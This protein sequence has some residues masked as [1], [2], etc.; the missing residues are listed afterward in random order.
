MPGMTPA[1]AGEMAEAAAVSLESQSHTQGVEL[2]V[3]AVSPTAYQLTWST[4][5]L[6]SIDA[7]N[8]PDDATEAGAVAVAA[9]MTKRHLGYEIIRRSRKGEGIDY[10]LGRTGTHAK[11]P[12]AAL[13]VSGIRSGNAAMI[14]QRVTLKREQASRFKT[15][16]SAIPT[17]V[18]VVEFGRPQA[19]I[20]ES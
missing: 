9:I 18:I 20:D 16:N 3:E 19:W 13:E 7:W 10:E 6:N 2:R 17:F 1:I 5:P 12:S 8:D 15:R 4:P 14:R 11:V